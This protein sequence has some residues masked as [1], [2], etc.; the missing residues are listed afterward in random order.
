MHR[1]VAPL[2][3][4]LFLTGFNTPLEAKTANLPAW[5]RF[6]ATLAN[7]PQIGKPLKVIAFLEALASDLKD[8]RLTLTLPAGWTPATPTAVL[9]KLAAGATQ[10][11]SF[12]VTPKSASPNGAISAQFQATTTKSAIV[13]AITA[14]SP[15]EVAAMAAAVEALPPRPFGYTDIAFALYPEEGFYPLGSDMWRHYEDKLTPAGLMRGPVLFRDSVISLHQ[16]QTDVEMYE[17]L[18][19]LL[20][21]DPK[22]AAA[23]R[24]SGVD[25]QRKRQDYVLGLFVLAS[26]A[27]GQQKS[28]Q[29]E[30]ALNK[31]EKEYRED[32]K[33]LSPELFIAAGNLRGTVLWAKGDKKGAEE[34]LR[35]VFYQ[36]RKAPSQRYTLRNIG[37]L[38]HDRGDRTNAREMLRLALEMKPSYTLLEQEYALL[39]GK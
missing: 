38:M 27:F 22:A 39:K 23:I 30:Q 24:A 4:V 26:E 3:L 12:L 35:S 5:Y 21:T 2:L 18:H 20:Q 8:I 37:L 7:P 32:G 29:V 34:V 17:R 10:A 6:S 16:A 33:S 28:A 13:K 19:T 11:F 15:E 14:G 31:L 9:D 1:I 36:N 25:L